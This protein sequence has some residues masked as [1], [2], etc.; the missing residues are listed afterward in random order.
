MK[1]RRT[2]RSFF[3]KISWI[4]VFVILVTIPISISGK[5]RNATKPVATSLKKRQE[6]PVKKLELTKEQQ[7]FVEQAHEDF[8]ATSKLTPPSENL[9]DK[10]QSSVAD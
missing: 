6:T 1:N 9:Q 4:L 7:E 3:P 10:M 5:T 8:K 2:T